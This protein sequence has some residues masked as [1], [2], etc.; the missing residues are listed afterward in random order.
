MSYKL[1]RSRPLWELW[2]IE[3]VEGGRMATLTK[4]HHAIVDG[5]SGAGLGEILLDVTPEPRPAQEETVGSLVGVQLPGL[6]RRAVGAL[7]NVGIKPPFR[8]ARLVQ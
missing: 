2:V 5:V 3:G 1:D 6:G 8:I 4:M 7:I